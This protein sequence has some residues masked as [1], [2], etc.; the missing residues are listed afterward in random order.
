[1]TERTERQ[2]PPSGLYL[3]ENTLK[4]LKVVA[5]MEGRSASEIAEVAI[6]SYLLGRVR[7]VGTIEQIDELVNRVKQQIDRSIKVIGSGDSGK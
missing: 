6:N 2:K 5:V 7:E 4:L 1:M 3:K